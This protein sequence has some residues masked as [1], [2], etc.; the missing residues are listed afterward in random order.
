MWRVESV[1]YHRGLPCVVTFSDTGYRCGYV[2]VYP[3]HPWYG[4]SYWDHYGI[5]VHGGL[6]YSRPSGM[7]PYLRID[8]VWWF[9]FD[10][11][12]LYDGRDYSTLAKY[13]PNAWALENRFPEFE[14]HSTIK[15]QWYVEEECKIL[16]TQL[17]LRKPLNEED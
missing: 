3:K 8:P 16:A 15:S 1:F 10:C 17:V 14:L 12:H 9:G 13:F 2:G 6:T 5:Y 4:D 11:G 7:Y